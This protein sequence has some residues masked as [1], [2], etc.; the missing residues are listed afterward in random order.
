VAF[1]LGMRM[2]LQSHRGS[3]RLRQSL[4]LRRS[5]RLSQRL[6][7]SL[8]LRL[9]SLLV[10][11]TDQMWSLRCR[12]HSLSPGLRQRL[13]LVP[14]WKPGR[15]PQPKVAGKPQRRQRGPKSPPSAAPLRKSP[16][17]TKTGE[18][19]VRSVYVAG[20]PIA[21]PY[22]RTPELTPPGQAGQGLG[23]EG[24]GSPESTTCMQL[25]T[26]G[27]GVPGGPPLSAPGLAA[28]A[29]AAARAAAAAPP[30]GSG[31]LTLLA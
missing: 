28:L 7:R 19:L 17:I 3:Q 18:P 24:G 11:R 16:R 30:P 8:R 4:K 1:H 2:F 14:Q 15:K 6:S 31:G 22:T 13:Q 23:A 29:R 5:P 9:R 27:A 10:L 26:S 25:P 20:K 12:F 21:V